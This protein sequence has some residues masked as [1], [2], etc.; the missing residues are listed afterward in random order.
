VFW[1][2]IAERS[3][4]PKKAQKKKKEEK[5]SAPFNEAQDE[6]EDRETH[7]FTRNMILRPRPLEDGRGDWSRLIWPQVMRKKRGA[8]GDLRRPEATPSTRLKRKTWRVDWRWRRHSGQPE[9]AGRRRSVAGQN[10]LG[11]SLVRLGGGERKGR[12]QVETWRAEGGGVVVLVLEIKRGE[13]ED[14]GTLVV[15]EAEA[16]APLVRG[17]RQ[18]RERSVPLRKKRGPGWTWA[19][20]RKLGWAREEEMGR[21]WPREGGL[22]RIG[23]A[24]LFLLKH[25]NSKPFLF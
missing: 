21:K 9:S 17:R 3:T 1:E 7:D 12:E 2:E 13:R 23:F 19:T 11:L 6:E 10:P 24:V 16:H 22:V 14:H 20:G 4:K 15:M 18:G 25:L 5:T 8:N